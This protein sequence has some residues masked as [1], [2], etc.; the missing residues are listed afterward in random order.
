MNQKFISVERSLQSDDEITLEVEFPYDLTTE[1]FSDCFY[2]LTSYSDGIYQ[3]LFFETLA[4]VLM[5]LMVCFFGVFFFPIASGLLGR[6]DFR[7]IGFG[8]LCFFAGL[9]MLIGRISDYMNLWI[10]DPPSV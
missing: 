1:S 3:K 5:F 2:V 10:I 7:Y 8:A 6:I 4:P 9:Y